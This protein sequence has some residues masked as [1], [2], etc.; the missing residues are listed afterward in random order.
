MQCYNLPGVRKLEA[1]QFEF[2]KNYRMCR[3]AKGTRN[4]FA[5][6][7]SRPQVNGKQ[8]YT[9]VKGLFTLPSLINENRY[10]FRIIERK[11]KFLIQYFL[12]EKSEARKCLR[13]WYEE[14]ELPLRLTQDRTEPLRHIFLNI[15]KGECASNA[16]IS[17]L[18][19][20]GIE[21]TSACS[22]TPEQYMVIE[23]V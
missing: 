6:A 21:L 19:G 2:L 13:N 8:W 23:I 3:L 12:K 9:V 15:D 18:K 17:F 5:G 14:Y 4:S 22:Y 7:M 20:V 10:V 1:K 16:T 11:S